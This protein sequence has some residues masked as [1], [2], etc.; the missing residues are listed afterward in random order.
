ME[1]A[2]QFS[3]DLHILIVSSLGSLLGLSILTGA[4]TEISFFLGQGVSAEA[5]AQMYNDLKGRI[6]SRFGI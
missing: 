4:L 1:G 5:I 6:W 2:I 3:N